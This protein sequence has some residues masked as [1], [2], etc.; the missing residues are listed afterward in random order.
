MTA[1]LF[2]SRSTTD[3]PQK[4]SKGAL[5]TVALIEA[6]KGVIVLC[7]GFGVLSLL[8]RDIER[9]AISLVTRLHI[10]PEAHYTGVFIEA[11]SRTTDTRLWGFA[12]LAML[13]SVLRLCE[14]YGLWFDHRWGLWFGVASGGIYLPVELYEL[15]HKPGWIKVGTLF[16]NLVV[17]AYLAGRLRRESSGSGA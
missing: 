8:H 3:R 6:V 11:A 12:A 1:N 9:I 16:V 5:R 7:A 17:I 2:A 13:Y 15:W 10:D 14:A 4:T